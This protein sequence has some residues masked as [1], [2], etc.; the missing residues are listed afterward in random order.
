MVQ[1]LLHI[2]WKNVDALNAMG[3]FCDNGFPYTSVIFYDGEEQK[4]LAL[5]SAED[6]KAE[7]K[8]KE[9][10]TEIIP[11]TTFYDAEEYHQNYKYKNP[12]RYKY[13]RW[14]CGRDQRLKELWEK[15]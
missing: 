15:V 5:K 9:I 8:A 11:Y 14:N 1:Q 13:Y 3:Q 7:L 4:K 10:F 2:F 12:I 6:V